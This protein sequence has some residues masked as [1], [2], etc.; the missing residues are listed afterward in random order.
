MNFYNTISAK[1]IG[2]G[3][4]GKVKI[5]IH[6]PTQQRVAIKILD[7]SK[8][9]D[10]TDVERITREIHILKTLRH[11]N[12]VQLYDTVTSNRHIYLIME[13]AEG[14]DL[15][16][17]INSKKKLDEFKACQLFQ[18]LI[19]AIEYIHKLGI[20][21]RDIKPE[22]I[23]LDEKFEMIKL[24]DFGL[25]NSYKHGDFVKT[26]CGSPCYAAP[27]MISG[28]TYN[29]LISDLWS[30]GVVLY[31]MLCGYLPFDDD[32][33]KRLYRK[34][35]EGDYKM[36]NSLSPNAKSLISGILN[37]DP[38][39]R[40]TIEK[41]R[42]HPWFNLSKF[43][44]DKGIIIGRDEILIDQEIVEEVKSSSHY[45]NNNKISHDF[46]RQTI[47]KNSHN[48]IST[49][50]YL[51]LK[52]KIKT[53]KE[54]E[55]ILSESNLEKMIRRPSRFN[56]IITANT[57][58]T[59]NNTANNS[60]TSPTKPA[61]PNKKK[62]INRGALNHFTFSPKNKRY[63]KI[64]SKDKLKNL[65]I[66]NNNTIVSGTNTNEN[67]M[68]TNSNNENTEDNL[69]KNTGTNN[70]R[71]N[72][73]FLEILDNSPIQTQTQTHMNNIQTQTYI[74][75]EIAANKSVNV[76]VINNIMT[77][78]PSK[79]EIP[80][81]NMNNLNF[82]N[83]KV[84][85]ANLTKK[86]NKG[87]TKILKNIK[88][89]TTVTNDNKVHQN[90]ESFTKKNNI[91]KTKTN[92]GNNTNQNKVS[93]S[94]SPNKSNKLDK[95]NSIIN[96]SELKNNATIYEIGKM[97]KEININNFINDIK[98]A[99][100]EAKEINKLNKTITND[101]NNKALYPISENKTN[102]VNQNK[103][104]FLSPENSTTNL[105]NQLDQLIKN[106]NTPIYTNLNKKNSEHKIPSKITDLG[107]NKINND[108]KTL[109][110][111]NST[112]K[113]YS[114]GTKLMLTNQFNNLSKKSNYLNYQIFNQNLIK[115]KIDKRV[116]NYGKSNSNHK[117]INYNNNTPST[118]TI[119]NGM[120]G[121]SITS[122]NLNQSKNDTKELTKG[123]YPHLKRL[124]DN[125]SFNYEN[126]SYYTKN[127]NSLSLNFSNHTGSKLAIAGE[128]KIKN[129]IL[130][131]Q[132][133]IYS[134]NNSGKNNI[135]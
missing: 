46:I 80:G 64:I 71:N 11:S 96:K 86:M 134:R 114:T 14:G 79:T 15:F 126:S 62:I 29:G 130:R 91:I 89:P 110:I 98:N 118:S 100:I 60:I 115:N 57:N 41:I 113:E 48:N 4:F 20:V 75:T 129:I 27:E 97:N 35:T 51:L 77:E 45:K 44:L 103:F 133:N 3:T 28:K 7:K 94:I 47:I 30:C 49:T 66:V 121:F 67:V 18:Q 117:S 43:Q 16:E 58:N 105:N 124:Y 63:S 111:N 104:L 109:T 19:S 10:E 21:H 73:N 116:I 32:N 68:T 107:N 6:L 56:Q 84:N 87:N 123:K 54:K 55:K 112:L 26:A 125:E 17:F 25:S 65:S 122:N 38:D 95:K 102:S 39:R 132:S 119:K 40:Y 23:L 50:Y 12:I 108:N 36:P 1:T 127:E 131:P 9:K 37:T 42:Q 53:L 59:I 128:N 90:N 13:Y 74:P 81:L 2:Q 8:I 69:N 72:I 99:T 85:F 52:K 106:K 31:C 83:I 24:V 70:T 33:I 78:I 34:I 92:P 5:G 22:N 93:K 101:S 135:K 82:N 61:S 88:N 76:V 120:T